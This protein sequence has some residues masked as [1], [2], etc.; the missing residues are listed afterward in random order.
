MN[1][2][3]IYHYALPPTQAGATR[4]YSH[5]RELIARGHQVQIVACSF[6]HWEHQHIPMAPGRW[7]EQ[8]SYDGVPFHWIHARGYRTNGLARV[9]NMLEFGYR[10]WRRDW[11][12]GLA[13][14]DLVV[15][16]NPHPL[17]AL[18]AERW[19]ARF[20]VPFVLEVADAWPYAMIEAGGFPAWHPYVLWADH[21]MRYLYRKATRI[22]MSSDS[23]ADL[24]VRYGA[25]R[26]KLVA[27]PMGVDL[28]LHPTPTPP[29]DDQLFTV[30]YLGAHNYWNSLDVVL[31]AAKLLQRAGVNNLLFR[32]VGDGACKTALIKR[33]SSEG[34]TNVRFDDPVPKRDIPSLAH[35]SDAFIINTRRDGVAK[36]WMSFNK[37]YDYL[38]AGRPVVFGCCAGDNPVR[39]AD[40]GISVEADNAAELA[41]A[42][43][44]L[45]SLPSDKIWAYGQRGRRH[46]EENYAIPSL[47]DR[48]EKMALEAISESR[49]SRVLPDTSQRALSPRP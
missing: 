18:A 20:G 42:V 4:H 48:F 7:W 16:L 5:G 26:K 28:Q 6:H 47:V 44:Q 25:E 12:E 49:A 17:A 2:W 33:A 27:I 10:A 43:A 31:D 3:Y 36:E 37:L 9:L 29:P 13:A 19:A 22:V 21:T 32:L 45:A 23:S 14:P 11:A 40:A 39:D 24:L 1:I 35:A 34:I 30:T 46:I 41:R 8:R 15:G 38:A